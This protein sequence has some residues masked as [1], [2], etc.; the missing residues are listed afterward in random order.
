MDAWV[1]LLPAFTL[2]ALIIATHTYLGLHVLARRILFVDL[3][4]AH[5]AALGVSIAHSMVCDAH[6]L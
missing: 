1:I 3:V 5:V 4:F 6:G 2:C